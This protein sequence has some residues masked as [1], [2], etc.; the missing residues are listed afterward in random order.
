MTTHHHG[1]TLNEFQA[2]RLSVTCQYID[3]IVGDRQQALHA[4]ESNAAFPPYQL[5]FAVAQCLAIKDTVQAIRAQLR[6]ILDSLAIPR[7]AADILASQAVYAGLTV[8]DIAGENCG[9]VTCGDMG[10]RLNR[11]LRHAGITTF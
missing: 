1:V 10:C 11:W 8:I 2:R 3:N 9:R 7:P 4:A 5:D 6:E